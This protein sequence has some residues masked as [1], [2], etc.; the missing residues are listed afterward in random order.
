[1]VM[2]RQRDVSLTCIC[3]CD[4]KMERR[5]WEVNELYNKPLGVYVMKSNRFHAIYY[6]LSKSNIKEE[7]F[8]GCYKE[9]HDMQLR[10][11]FHQF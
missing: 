9:C 11:S 3:G 1:M 4:M 10:E 5:G 6:N 8:L 2:K 7:I